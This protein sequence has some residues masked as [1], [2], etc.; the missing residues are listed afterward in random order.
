MMPDTPL[1]SNAKGGHPASRESRQP[2]EGTILIVNDSPS[3]IDP[4]SDVLRR[5]GYRVLTAEG[6]RGGYQVTQRERPRLVIIGAG[7]TEPTGA[8]L[9]RLIRADADL[10]LVPILIV[11]ATPVDTADAVGGLH[12]GADDYLEV[13][14]DPAQLV[15]QATRLIERARFEAMLHEAEDRSRRQIELSPDGTLIHIEGK[16]IFI[17]AAGVELLGATHPD[18]ILGKSVIDFVHHDYKEIV[19]ER[20]LRLRGAGMSAPLIE[21]KLVRLD[22][23]EVDVEAKCVSFNH[24]GSLAVQTVIRDTSERKAAVEALRRSDER[25]LQSQKMESIGT[26]AGGVAHDFNNLLTVILGN[27]QMALRGLEPDSA[28]QARL[29]E[30]ER[31]GNRAAALTRQLLAFS[32]RQHLER[33]II[34]LND[35][36]NEIMKMLRRIIGEDVEVEVLGAPDLSPVFADP[37]QIEQVV[38]NLAVNARDAMPSGGR[39]SITTRDIELDE[40]FVN[41][42]PYAKAGR[43][44]QMMVSDTGSGM[45]GEVRERIFEPF[46]TTKEIGK[47][48]GL[49]LAMVYGIIKQHEGII[50]VYSEEGHGT[51]F[52]MY[53]P[54]AGA[55]VG[56]ESHETQP[57]LRGGTETIL[58]AEDEEALRELARDILEEL[59]YT[60]MLARDGEEA[61]EMFTAGRERIDM[62][63]LDL[64]MPRLGGFEAYVRMQA[65]SPGLPALFMTGYS[66]ELVRSQFVKQNKALEEMGAIIIQ[67]PYSVEVLGHKVREVLDAAQDGSP[68]TTSSA[69]D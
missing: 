18:Q 56:E 41:K 30:V 47:G 25:L 67:K 23:A 20:V 21:G 36:I 31:A 12:P 6:G 26:L 64:V 1:T 33:K 3:R 4:M 49:G 24:H 53:L 55:T 68:L 34:N 44:V 15:A 50:H 45:P 66:V 29:L 59:G 46:F 14:Y 37:A 51:I 5:A 57:L 19:K 58:I 16:I 8:E 39:L 10:H 42:Y 9:C 7:A 11:S 63:M 22:G 60:V 38:M 35:T 61:V 62:V 32:R 65:L 40:A 13:P 28:L 17:N 69:L 54:V 48:T 52:I 43:Y 2:V 27:I